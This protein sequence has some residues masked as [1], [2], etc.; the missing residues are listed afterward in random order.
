MKKK[1]EKR[2]LLKFIRSGIRL[3][4]KPPKQETPKTVYNR[5]KQKRSLN[6]D[7]SFVLLSSIKK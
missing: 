2:D 6:E 3:K 1:D 7:S 4:T 5:R